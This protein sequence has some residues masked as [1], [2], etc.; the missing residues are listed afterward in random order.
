MG[1]AVKVRNKLLSQSH[2]SGEFISCCT[3]LFLGNPVEYYSPSCFWVFILSLSVSL[4]HQTHGRTHFSAMH[5]TC[6]LTFVVTLVMFVRL[7][8]LTTMLFTLQLMCV[9]QFQFQAKRMKKI[10][11]KIEQLCDRIS[12]S[13]LCIN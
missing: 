12:A 5:A 1:R 7:Y 11:V 4:P 6:Q 10:V 3:I 13:P 9:L 8:L 2:E